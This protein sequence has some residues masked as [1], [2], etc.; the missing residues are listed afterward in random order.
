MSE[1]PMQIGRP[2][3]DGGEEAGLALLNRCRTN[4]PGAYDQFL[5]RYTRRILNTAY[6]I[7]GEESSAE[8]ALQETLINVYRGLSSFRG[9]SK[10]STWV[11]RITVNVC[12]GI[13]RKARHRHF[14]DLEDETARELPAMPTPETDPLEHT[15]SEELRDLVAATFDRMSPKQ[16]E[17]VRLHDMQGHTIQEIARIIRCPAGTVKSRLFYGR[18]E[19]KSI[20]S[21]LRS[22]GL[23]TAAVTVQ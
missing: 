23:A 13:L 15:A 4:D 22:K 8:D 18:Q 2:Q 12:L 1:G 16:G 20:F 14:V 9:D 5:S 10:V 19:F 3:W 21:R 7:L 11:S 6:R 17:V